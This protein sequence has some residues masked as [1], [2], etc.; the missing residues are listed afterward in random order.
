MKDRLETILVE[1]ATGKYDV[2]SLDKLVG[3]DK[4]A[5]MLDFVQDE[6]LD[7]SDKLH[8]MRV[9]ETISDW[10]YKN[11]KVL[12]YVFGEFMGRYYDGYSDEEYNSE[13]FGRHL[14][15]EE[16]SNTC[17]IDPK[18]QK[19]VVS[20]E[21]IRI[22]RDKEIKKFIKFINN[23]NIDPQDFIYLSQHYVNFN[24]FTV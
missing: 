7:V 8:Y 13:W 3:E 24:Y 6:D 17:Y 15:L 1:I 20:R 4:D 11:T 9:A 16:I 14:T 2:A 19:K 22:V 18:G 12:K 5:S 23:E 10:L 21:L